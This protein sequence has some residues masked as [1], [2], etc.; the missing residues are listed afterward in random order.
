[1]LDKYQRRGRE[2]RFVE[3]PIARWICEQDR[4]APHPSM[5]VFA[6][7]G[8]ATCVWR[9]S[10]QAVKYW[11]TIVSSSVLCSPSSPEAVMLSSFLF[12]SW[13]K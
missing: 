11:Y 10:L 1:M 5:G 7:A 3:T 6:A 2:K 12:Q 8:L 13:Q 4:N 9:D